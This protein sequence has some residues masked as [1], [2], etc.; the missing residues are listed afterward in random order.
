MPSWSRRSISKKECLNV[1]EE[2]LDEVEAPTG[3]R[4][5]QLRTGVEPLGRARRRPL[6]AAPRRGASSEEQAP[7][8]FMRKEEEEKDDLMNGG[9]DGSSDI[10][11]RDMGATPHRQAKRSSDGKVWAPVV[12]APASGRRVACPE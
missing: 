12:G 5:V 8:L 2:A 11:A 7:P 3:D 1:D 6:S 10:C 9:D 4:E